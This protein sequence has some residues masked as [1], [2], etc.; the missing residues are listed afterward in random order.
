MT[1][2]FPENKPASPS[3]SGAET[4]PLSRACLRVIG[5]NVLGLCALVLLTALWWLIS[6]LFDVLL[7][8]VLT[9]LATYLLLGLVDGF[10]RFKLRFLPAWGWLQ[11]R[12]VT[13]LLIYL[14]VALMGIGVSIQALP[15]LNRQVHGL[16]H[17]LPAYVQQLNGALESL[18]IQP[19]ALPGTALSGGGFGGRN[20]QAGG[21]LQIPVDASWLNTALQKEPPE[22]EQTLQA[23]SLSAALSTAVGA[24][25][26]DANRASAGAVVAPLSSESSASSDLAVGGAHSPDKQA[27][28]SENP[29][30][31]ARGH[32]PW[33]DPFLRQVPDVPVPEPPGPMP[34]PATPASAGAAL[35]EPGAA[36]TLEGPSVG[37]AVRPTGVHR[38]GESSHALAEKQNQESNTIAS[39]PAATLPRDVSPPEAQTTNRITAQSTAA[40]TA[41][42]KKASAPDSSRAPID[43]SL[44]LPIPAEKQSS[45]VTLPQ[46]PAQP[47]IETL[48]LALSP[49]PLAQPE[50]VSALVQSLGGSVLGSLLDVGTTTVT[51]VVY[52]LTGLVLA[53][54]FLVD[55]ARLGRGAANLFPPA[56]AHRVYQRLLQAHRFLKGYVRVQ[57][58]VSVVTALAVYAVYWLAGV[59]YAGF[60]SAYYGVCALVPVVGSVMGLLPALVITL[61]HDSAWSFPCLVFGITG[62]MLLRQRWLLPWARPERPKLHPAWGT[63]VFLVCLRLVGLWAV[64][65]TFPLV[66]LIELRLRSNRPAKPLPTEN[67]PASSTV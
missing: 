59:K 13:V 63:L 57:I 19:V 43:P 28:L 5:I 34:Q 53:F 38:G 41:V 49:A 62:L 33:E 8:L 52:A 37:Q 40:Q 45:A 12:A 61:F 36:E 64:V 16:L 32:L 30:A 4:T 14:W 54:Y 24:P 18:G 48:R 50:D 11:S 55:G 26:K 9:L 7:L 67:T 20:L 42:Q 35:P 56:M 66:G 21:T 17:E 44:P 31:E 46:K 60:L 10:H 58:G 23:P 2:P 6:Y 65:L 29:P 47:S 51:V 25:P 15:V 27:A 39:P 1:M 22:G 3:A